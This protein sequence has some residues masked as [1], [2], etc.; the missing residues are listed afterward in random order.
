MI[1]ESERLGEIITLGSHLKRL[2]E[3][4]NLNIN[5]PLTRS[6]HNLSLPYAYHT[7]VFRNLQQILNLF[8][9][10]TWLFRMYYGHNDKETLKSKYKKM[11]SCI[12]SRARTQI[13][14][15]YHC[16]EPTEFVTG[17]RRHLRTQ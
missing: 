15:G 6:N 7:L 8:H 14:Q 13:E 10:P 5:R 4:P 9:H 17:K 16:S 12:V 1:R 2:K 3:L 11:M